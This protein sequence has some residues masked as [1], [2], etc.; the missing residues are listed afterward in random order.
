MIPFLDLKVLNSE[1][2]DEILA[3]MAAVLDSGSYIIGPSV[4]QF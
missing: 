3:A 2:R 4:D 1:Q